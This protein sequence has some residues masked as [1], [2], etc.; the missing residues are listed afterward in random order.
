MSAVVVHKIDGREREK[1]ASVPT[2]VRAFRRCKCH[3]RVSAYLANWNSFSNSFDY[4]MKINKEEAHNKNLLSTL[5][6]PHRGR[7]D[8][9]MW[10]CRV[11]R[12]RKDPTPDWDQRTAPSEL[13]NQIGQ[14]CNV[15]SDH[16]GVHN[17]NW[18]TKLQHIRTQV[19]EI[20][21]VLLVPTQ[22]DFARHTEH[23]TGTMKLH[24]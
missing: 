9:D 7:A 17:V 11:T 16:A 5:D 10:R 15:N 6:L 19:R 8:G 12:S 23:N 1:K 20:Y 22:V 21:K 18:G 24:V 4:T 14:L 13:K 3:R 2:D